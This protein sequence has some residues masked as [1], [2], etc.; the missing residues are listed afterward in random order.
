MKIAC[1]ADTHRVIR[2]G[3]ILW[4]EADVLVCAGDFCNIGS[5]GDAGSFNYWL[6]MEGVFEIY[7]HIIVVAGNH[8]VVFEKAPELAEGTLDDRIIYLCDKAKT[9]NGVKFYGS[10]WQLPFNNWAFNKE[11]DELE[12]LFSRIPKD[13]DVLITHSPPYEILDFVPGVDGGH[14]G[15]KSLLDKV[16]EVAPEIHIFG[17]IHEAYGQINKSCIQFANATL[18]D[19]VYNHTHPVTVLEVY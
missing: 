13:T 16:M 6:E 1:F 2:T 15:S 3:N 18:L 14:K 12:V 10:P 7:K 5:I 4:P 11:E 19:G 8:D 9:I 17:H